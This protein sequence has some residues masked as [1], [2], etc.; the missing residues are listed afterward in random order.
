[1]LALEECHARGFGWKSMGMCNDAKEKVNQCI[2]GEREKRAAANRALA[3]E[4][5]DKVKK[6]REEL[7]ME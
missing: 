7:G 2:R 4:K 1:M 6:A 3:R 5:R